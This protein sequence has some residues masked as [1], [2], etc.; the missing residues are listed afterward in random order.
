M[1]DLNQYESHLHKVGK[2]INYLV[3]VEKTKETKVDKTIKIL[4]GNKY[5][6]LEKRE[7]KRA[8]AYYRKFIKKHKY[9]KILSKVMFTSAKQ[10]YHIDNV[11]KETIRC[12]NLSYDL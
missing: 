4:I 7:F 11:F 8:V 1:T 6:Q 9:K 2:Y 10:N 12:I 5:D 3:N